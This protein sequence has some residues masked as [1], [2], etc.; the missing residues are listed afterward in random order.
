MW[1]RFSGNLKTTK[2]AADLFYNRYDKH[3]L[4][5]DAAAKTFLLDSLEDKFA[6]VVWRKVK[7][8][9][10]FPMV[11]LKLIQLAIAPSLDRW[12]IIKDKIKSALPT[13]YPG[14][15]VRSLCQDFGDWGKALQ[16]G[17]QYDHSLTRVMVKNVLKSKDLPSTYQYQLSHLQVQVDTALSESTY[18]SYSKRWEYMEEKEVTFEDVCEVVV[19]AY[20]VFFIT[21]S[22]LQQRFPRIMQQC[23]SDTPTYP[24][25][26]SKTIQKT[27]RRLFAIVVEP[28]DT[29]QIAAQ[30]FNR[31]KGRKALS[32]GSK[33]LPVKVSFSQRS[34]LKRRFIGAL[35]AR[36]GQLRTP[37]QV[38]LV[39][40][41]LPMNQRGHQPASSNMILLFGACPMVVLPPAP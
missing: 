31:K 23:P 30:L 36:G 3:D 14:Q 8:D 29:S 11:W 41:S 40:A 20:D 19:S 32:L 1:Y 15:N 12:D 4:S 18:M 16:Q 39:K 2:V 35:S 27:R 33:F 38:M 13:D 34:T 25:I 26:L 37:L 22:G 6:Q 24:V 9:D 17:G 5:N 7:E 28:K 21:K 10:S